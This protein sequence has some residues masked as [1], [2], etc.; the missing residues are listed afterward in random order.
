VELEKLPLR[1]VSIAVEVDWDGDGL[2]TDESAHVVSVRGEARLSAPD[3]LLTGGGGQVARC[4][5]ALANGDRRFS[6][7]N[8]AS[9]LYAYIAAGAAHQAR[10]RVTVTVAG[11]AHRVFT[12]VVRELQETAP[13]AKQAATVTLECRGRDDLLLQERRSTPLADFLASSQAAAT[14]D[15]HLAAWLTLAGLVDGVDFVSRAYAAGHAGVQP[16]LDAGLFPLRYAWL[17]DE[18][19]LD[20]AWGLVGACCGWFY[21]DA[22][23]VFH[24]HNLTAVAPGALARQ[25]GAL[26]V[27]ELDEHQV[28]GLQLRWPTAE[29][30]GE[31]TVEVSPRGPGET[32]EVW[33]PDTVVVVQ[34]GETKTIWAR[35]DGPLAGAPTLEW[36]AFT[37]GGSPIHSGV[38]VSQTDYAQRVKLVIA[39]SGTRAAYLNTLR[40]SGQ[41][42]VGGRQVE[43]ARTS[44]A[45]FWANRTLRRRAI[46]NNVYLQEESQAETVAAYTL[47][48]QE[49]PV[50]VATVPN[51]DRPEVRLGWP[52]RIEYSNVVPAANAIVGIV[53]GLSWRAD[54]SG[55]RQDVTVLETGSLF[56]GHEPIFVLGVHRVGDG[57]GAGEGFLFY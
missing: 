20:E 7:L 3:A 6:S 32:G 23:G 33:A 46:R 41:L 31:V 53:T 34:P 17:D 39:N 36:A 24:Y 48:R 44:E 30:Y 54:H 12:G 51:V 21:C 50:L 9:P 27:V 28:A 19:L 2:Y 45:P 56:A 26:T 11:Q 14:E 57:M 8:P 13:T 38:T 37:A 1:L 25:V 15:V 10:M 16:T 49:R 42:L 40:L 5:V 35:L 4:A 29:L 43:V 22:E 18:S 55:F 52:V 47:R